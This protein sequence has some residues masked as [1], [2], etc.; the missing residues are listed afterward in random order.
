MTIPMLVIITQEH[1]VHGGLYED[2]KETEE[3]I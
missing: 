3:Y 1:K 2:I